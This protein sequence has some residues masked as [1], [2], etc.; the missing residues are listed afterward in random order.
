MYAGEARPIT[1][2]RRISYSE[3]VHGA[4]DGQES[5]EDHLVQS[6]DHRQPEQD[7]PQPA[8][9]ASDRRQPDEDHPEPEG[10][11][12]ESEEDHRRSRTVPPQEILTLRLARR[13]DRHSV[14]IT[15]STASA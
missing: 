12:E 1:A 6:H 8:A 14:V 11:P 9:P 15:F 3:S 7:P 4:C 10:D 2:E 13:H 5:A